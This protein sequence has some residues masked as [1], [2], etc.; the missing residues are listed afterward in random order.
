MS[1]FVLYYIYE[2]NHCVT[3]VDYR[4]NRLF[5]MPLQPKNAFSKHFFQV[6][7]QI[8]FLSNS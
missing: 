2:D 7:F 4:A 5:H 8:V 6:M 1:I 3:L